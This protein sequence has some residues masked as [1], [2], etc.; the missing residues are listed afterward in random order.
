ME[1]ISIHDFKTKGLK[2]YYGAS[3]KVYRNSHVEK[4]LVMWKDLHY[5][6]ELKTRTKLVPCNEEFLNNK[7]IPSYN[8]TL[9]RLQ[10]KYPN[11]AEFNNY[12]P[13]V[14]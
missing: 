10:A 12:K 4:L 3:K 6:S 14:K 7:A 11:I 8:S 13:I 9:E 1:Q 5:L 2:Q